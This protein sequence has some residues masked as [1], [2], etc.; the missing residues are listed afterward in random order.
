MN[1]D[2]IIR[3][4]EC[5]FGVVMFVIP[6]NIPAGVYHD[7]LLKEKGQVVDRMLEAHKQ[8]QEYARLMKEE[9]IDV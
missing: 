8:E 9:Q 4:Q 6:K 1:E 2:Y 5:E 3:N 7:V